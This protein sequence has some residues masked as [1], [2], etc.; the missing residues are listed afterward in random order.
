[1]A[2]VDVPTV[3]EHQP[4]AIVESF[5]QNVVILDDVVV[6]SQQG[7]E[8]SNTTP[9]GTTL[10]RPDYPES[11]VAS[12]RRVS[13]DRPGVPLH[14][15][16]VIDAFADL[17]MVCAVLKAGHDSAFPE[18]TVKAAV[19]ADIVVLDWKIHESAGDVA[20]S[21]IK[22]ILE[23]DQNNHRLRLIA[24]YTGETDLGDI[25]ERIQLAIQDFYQDEEVDIANPSCITKGPLRVL[26]LAKEG[27]LGGHGPGLNYDEV[28]E[29][30][31]AG[32][33][34]DEF[35][36]MTSGLLRN[37]ALAGIATIRKKAHRVLARFNEDLDPAYLGHRLLLPHPPDAEDH[38][39]AALGSE[40]LSVLEEER[41]GEHA[42]IEAIE[43]WLNRADGPDISKPLTLSTPANVVNDC[44]DLLLRG[45]DATHTQYIT[46]KKKL[47]AH[48]TELFTDSPTTA[49]RSNENFAALLNLKTRYP[50]QRPR[51]TIGAVLYTEEQDRCQYLL[52]LQPKCDSIR[53]KSASG[54]PFIPLATAQEE[55]RKRSF[56][57]VVEIRTGEWETLG[58]V[59]KPSELIMRSFHAGSNPPGEVIAIK[60]K[61]GEFYFEDVDKKRYHWVAEMKEEHAFRVAAAVASALARPGPNDAEWLRRSFR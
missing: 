52:C 1:M 56:P 4:R 35:V 24:I 40:L 21:V 27:T 58:V 49:K 19:R 22:R 46:S 50:G 33:L 12:D 29:G 9:P 13:S 51:L 25:S 6:M 28:T 20:L 61:P 44:L 55:N 23:A 7:E 32:R 47:E 54:F 30:A 14:A 53:L 41:P 36:S 15:D 37:V 39:V 18:R 16:T 31:L 5:L 38:L 10:R 34:V 17:G 26:I 2:D 43:R 42:D 48:G 60:D 57:L 45:I 8:Q 59:P 3:S 11:T